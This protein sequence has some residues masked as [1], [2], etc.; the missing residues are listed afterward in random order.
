MII[1]V[2]LMCI[3]RTFSLCIL[4]FHLCNVNL[5]LLIVSAL[6]WVEVEYSRGILCFV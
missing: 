6:G 4:N 2:I 1:D 3:M 5:F